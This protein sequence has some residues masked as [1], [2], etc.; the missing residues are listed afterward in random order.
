MAY[1]SGFGS[2]V[3][4]APITLPDES[5]LGIAPPSMTRISGSISHMLIVTFV[6][7]TRSESFSAM[8]KSP[9]AFFCVYS[10]P[11]ST[12]SDHVTEM[13]PDVTMTPHSDVVSGAPHS[14]SAVSRMRRPL[15][16]R[17][18]LVGIGVS[19]GV[20]FRWDAALRGSKP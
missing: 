20:V 7:L 9:Q 8:Q 3:K 18:F 14:S 10:S 12:S 1:E 11:A 19:Y 6:H 4:N 13:N 2:V 17:S 15:T 5:S 16:E